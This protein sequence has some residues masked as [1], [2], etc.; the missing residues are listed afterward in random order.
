MTTQALAPHRFAIALAITLVLGSGT[1]FAAGF[2]EPTGALPASW[3][4]AA[5]MVGDQGN[6]TY[7]FIG[8]DGHVVGEDVGYLDFLREKVASEYAHDGST[9]QVHRLTRWQWSYVF[10]N[11]ADGPRGWTWAPESSLVTG[12]D[13][14]G[15]MA[16]LESAA[17]DPLSA[18][19]TSTSVGPVPVQALAQQGSLEFQARVYMETESGPLP[20]FWGEESFGFCGARNVLQG[21]DRSLDDSLELFNTCTI[22]VGG[23]DPTRLRVED[24]GAD[25]LEISMEELEGAATEVLVDTGSRWKP[26]G[27]QDIDGR[28]TVAFGLL[29]KEGDER[30]RA[31]RVWFARDVPY[32]VQLSVEGEK[33]T[34]VLRLTRF[35]PGTQPIAFEAG[36][37]L[38][39]PPE[40]RQASRRD[41]GMD[42][43]GVD[44]RLPA[45]VAWQAALDEGQLAAFLSA[46]PQAVVVDARTNVF[47]T[48]D[49]GESAWSRFILTDGIE[50][51]EVEV[52]SKYDPVVPSPTLLDLPI[53]AMGGE[54]TF[55]VE[56][57]VTGSG[58][59]ATFPT[60]GLPAQLPSVTSL[61][62]RLA[63][64]TA[65]QDVPVSGWEQSL[66]CIGESET[67]GQIKVCDEAVIELAVRAMDT[68]IAPNATTPQ[69]PTVETSVQYA[70]GSFTPDGKAR[71]LYLVGG[72]ATTTIVP[73]ALAP[74]SEV[75]FEA[76]EATDGWSLPSTTLVATA[77]L[78]GVLAG[79]AYLLWPLAK[80]GG[81]SLFSRVEGQQ[82]LEHPQRQ[83]LHAAIEAQPG[84]H[85]KELQRQTGLAWGQTQHHMAKL[86]ASGIIVAK[87]LGAYTCYFPK[88]Q[89]RHVMGAAGVLKADGARRLLQ[90]I[91]GTVGLS[92]GQLSRQVGLTESTAHYHVKRLEA[93]G[94]VATHLIDG[95]RRVTLTALGSEAG[96]RFGATAPA[97]A[98]A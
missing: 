41:W 58:I 10:E 32:P 91:G 52:R 7:A 85:L 44:V 72:A 25:D 23:V 13:A 63:G 8:K 98:A 76:P 88:G 86:V 38:P 22:R 77:G 71:A 69:S 2:A 50:L 36:S 82:L 21:K 55:E 81:L 19:G 66:E 70:F 48:G 78:L 5:P 92:M 60:Q 90:A 67:R 6:Y 17:S 62:T 40:A 59:V 18:D 12:S 83:R 15:R 95:A 97:E 49:G 30:G 11:G 89:D 57:G 61:A 53:E 43:S 96:R 37:D 28:P 31:V 45:S 80:G 64:F 47:A 56:V 9:V 33:G 54:P 24:D 93:A 35:Q 27:A 26:V 46:H 68:G 1:V 84:I 94:L 3:G 65:T 75:P 4:V 73:A 34:H 20:I 79:L 51:F 87:P 16:F 29:G 74:A 39:R 42:D 14:Q